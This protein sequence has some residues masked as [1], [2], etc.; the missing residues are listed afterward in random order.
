MNVR[1]TLGAMLYNN[2]IQ[3][4]IKLRDSVHTS[5]FTRIFIKMLLILLS[6]YRCKYL[7]GL[8]HCACVYNVLMCT[9]YTVGHNGNCGYAEYV[10]CMVNSAV[11]TSNHKH[12]IHNGKKS[13]S[14]CE[15]VLQTA[16]RKSTI[17]GDEKQ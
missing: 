4:A 11:K 12:V 9:V 5:H 14:M 8:V 2:N 17:G 13:N 15:C 7:Y 6:S 3:D 1:W 10:W 16:E